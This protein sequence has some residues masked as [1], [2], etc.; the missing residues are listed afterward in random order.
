[1]H[2]WT[3]VLDS[4]EYTHTN[5]S[6]TYALSILQ[7]FL[8]FLFATSAT[9]YS[10]IVSDRIYSLSET[11]SHSHLAMSICQSQFWAKSIGNQTVFFA[12]ISFLCT[13]DQTKTSS[14][15]R[16]D[17][18]WRFSAMM[19][20]FSQLFNHLILMHSNENVR[21]IHA[22]HC[23][24]CS[25]PARSHCQQNSLILFCMNVMFALCFVN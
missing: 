14:R 11:L 5:H 16:C 12:R 15:C 8:H 21:F 20:N 4:T 24:V 7:M 25:S 18:V 1:M 6:V 23:I 9:E 13:G 19:W 10:V 2:A 17:H 3:Y 22:Q